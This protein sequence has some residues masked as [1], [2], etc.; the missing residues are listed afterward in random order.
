MDRPNLER[1][2]HVTIGDRRDADAEMAGEK[3][4]A[5]FVQSE[6]VE[7]VSGRAPHQA[8]RYAVQLRHATRFI[9]LSRQ[10]PWSFNE[11]SEL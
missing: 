10:Y 5:D 3:A 2:F 4:R 11:T 6:S 8:A 7:L 1:P 9:Q